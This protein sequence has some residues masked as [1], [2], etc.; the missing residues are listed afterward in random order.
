MKAPKSTTFR[1]VP[2]QLHAGL[3]VFQL[4]NTLLEN[5]RRQI[6]ARV[7]ARAAQGFKDILKSRQPHLEPGAPLF[8]RNALEL[9]LELLRLLFLQ[10]RVPVAFPIR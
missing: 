6:F 4:E 5:G 2:L 7:A 8:R 10:Q 9:L 1:T 3:Q